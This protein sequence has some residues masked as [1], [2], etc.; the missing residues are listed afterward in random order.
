MMYADALRQSVHLNAA[1]RHFGHV[2]LDFQRVKHRAL[3]A[4][5][6]EQRQNPRARAEIHH[7]FAYARGRKVS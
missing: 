6:N 2:R 1:R 4:R 5:G 7:V 3:R